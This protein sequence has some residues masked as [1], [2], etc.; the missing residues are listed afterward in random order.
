MLL[1]STFLVSV[2]WNYI[3]NS[4]SFY[5]VG[6]CNLKKMKREKIKENNDAFIIYYYYMVGWKCWKVSWNVENATRQEPPPCERMLS[7]PTNKKTIQQFL[8]TTQSWLTSI[9]PV[10]C[11]LLPIGVD[12]TRYQN[13][14]DGKRMTEAGC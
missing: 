8:S 6:K 13:C 11:F 10:F 2:H 7:L 14:A 1:L 4:H 3:L 12:F 5:A 9:W